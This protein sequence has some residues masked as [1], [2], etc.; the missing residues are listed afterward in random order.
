[1][2]FT[3][4]K[5][6]LF[7]ACFLPLFGCAQKEIIDVKPVKIIDAGHITSDSTRPIKN[8]VAGY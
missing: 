3:P 5:R 7:A 2:I 8:P 6:L 4:K 1:M